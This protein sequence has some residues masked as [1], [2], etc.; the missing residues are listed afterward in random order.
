[1]RWKKFST[2]CQSFL[3]QTATIFEF[4]PGMK[5]VSAVSELL[6]PRDARLMRC[7]PVSSR[8]NSAVN[9]DEDALDAWNLQSFNIISSRRRFTAFAEV[10]RTSALVT[11]WSQS[12]GHLDKF[13]G[14]ATL[15]ARTRH[16][17]VTD[18]GDCGDGSGCNEQ[19]AVGHSLR[20]LGLGLGSMGISRDSAYSKP[21]RAAYTISSG[22][23]YVIG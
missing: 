2:E 22:I 6:R 7:Y 16:R 14:A 3:I 21:P 13:G 17:E 20:R 23:L 1:V 11:E 5:D 18:E 4:D 8:I 19:Y 15:Q 9:D 10:R 12:C